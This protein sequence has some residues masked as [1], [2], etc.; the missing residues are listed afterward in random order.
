MEFPPST[1]ELLVSI[2]SISKWYYLV[3]ILLIACLALTL[4]AFLAVEAFSDTRSTGLTDSTVFSSEYEYMPPR[5]LAYFPL[6]D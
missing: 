1:V 4:L 3:K 6:V 5:V 2:I